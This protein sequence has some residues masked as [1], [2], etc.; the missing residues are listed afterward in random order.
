VQKGIT[1]GMEKNL[2]RRVIFLCFVE[3]THVDEK[4]FCGINK[5]VFQKSA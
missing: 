2:C 3:H 1:K 4:F 5:I